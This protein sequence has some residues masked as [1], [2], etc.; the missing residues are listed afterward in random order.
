MLASVVP[1]RGRRWG[2]N[3]AF[4]IGPNGEWS[5]SSCRK[6]LKI[7]ED[8]ARI[9][10]A[11]RNARLSLTMESEHSFADPTYDSPG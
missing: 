10:A 4:A 1:T 6:T 5:Y 11:T 9:V 7:A 3:S 2:P 8:E